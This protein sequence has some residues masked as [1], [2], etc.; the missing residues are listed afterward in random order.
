MIRASDYQH[1]AFAEISGKFDLAR[2]LLELLD[3]IYLFLGPDSEKIIIKTS[4][5]SVILGSVILVV[6]T[7][8]QKINYLF[9][10]THSTS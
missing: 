1:H 7:Y 10:T 4:W 2:F 6:S 3:F 8:M 9:N 5:P